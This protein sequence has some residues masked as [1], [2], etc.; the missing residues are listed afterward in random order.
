M[1]EARFSD[2]PSSRSSSSD[3]KVPSKKR[4]SAR[5][6]GEIHEGAPRA[7]L[8]NPQPDVVARVRNEAEALEMEGE[9]ARDGE[10]LDR[11]PARISAVLP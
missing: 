3:Q 9:L 6:G 1:S 7:A 5:Y 2:A 11:E 10:R 4:Q 8:A